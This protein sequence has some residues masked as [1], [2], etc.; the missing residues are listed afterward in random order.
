M[1]L[2]RQ[3]NPA[4][5][6]CGEVKSMK[7]GLIKSAVKIYIKLIFWK[8][9]YKAMLEFVNVSLCK[10]ELRDEAFKN[11]IRLSLAEEG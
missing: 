9:S 5:I 10:T 6:P 2:A 7:L 11:G 1:G 4:A 3:G 8:F